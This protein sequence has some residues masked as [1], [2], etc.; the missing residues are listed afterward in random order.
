MTLFGGNGG[1]DIVCSNGGRDYI[2]AASGDEASAGVQGMVGDKSTVIGDAGVRPAL[3]QVRRSNEVARIEIHNNTF[4]TILARL[5][6]PSSPACLNESSHSS[7]YHRTRSHQN[8]VCGGGFG[9]G[10]HNLP[11]S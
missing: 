7:R 3:E 11:F 1:D 4:G 6:C 8:N 2:T 5:R 9:N 10:G